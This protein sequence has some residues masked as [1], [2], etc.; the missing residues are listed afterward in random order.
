[1]GAMGL[2]GH[3]GIGAEVS[4]MHLPRPQ[5]D[6]VRKHLRSQCEGLDAQYRCQSAVLSLH[7]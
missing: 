2:L 6:L 7:C 1:M 5:T 3:R 4:V